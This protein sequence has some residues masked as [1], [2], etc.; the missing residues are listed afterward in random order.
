MSEG[1]CVGGGV[2]VHVGVCSVHNRACM[3]SSIS[4]TTCIHYKLCLKSH[5]HSD[6]PGF[7]TT[8]HDVIV[9][10]FLLGNYT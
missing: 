8:W 7:E 3:I 5:S 1:V 10:D 6:V 9:C 2:S 4:T